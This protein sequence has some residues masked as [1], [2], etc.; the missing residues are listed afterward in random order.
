MKNQSKK[1]TLSRESLR[2]LDRADGKH[3]LAG[4]PE[5]WVGHNCNY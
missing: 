1:L 4:M 3:L 2:L 5:T